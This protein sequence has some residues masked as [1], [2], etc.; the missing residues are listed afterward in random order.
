MKIYVGLFIKVLFL[1]TI[2]FCTIK[3]M[4]DQVLVWCPYTVDC[5]PSETTCSPAHPSTDFR[6][7][8]PPV[9][10]NDSG[11]SHFYSARFN[12]PTQTAYCYYQ[13]NYPKMTIFYIQANSQYGV[14][15][16]LGSA[17]YQNWQL[18]NNDYTCSFGN[19]IQ[20]CPWLANY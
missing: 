2:I 20:N 17:I 14:I 1:F 10:P 7:Q 15:P 19:G 11:E 12:I 3:C 5:D 6:W 13:T 4:A 18:I 9:N 16:Y 8:M